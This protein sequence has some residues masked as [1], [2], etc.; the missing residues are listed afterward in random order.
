M[1]ITTA[2]VEPRSDRLYANYNINIT[3]N[4]INGV[5]DLNYV[6]VTIGVGLSDYCD[7]S[8]RLLLMFQMNN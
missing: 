1:E 8:Y 6:F 3:G 7:H 5:L 2:R 4:E